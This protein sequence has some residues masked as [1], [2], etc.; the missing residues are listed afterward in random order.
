MH[1]SIA[2]RLLLI[3]GLVV[4][5]TALITAAPASAA[6]MTCNLSHVTK[7]TPGLEQN[8]PPDAPDA[9]QTFAFHGTLTGCTGG[10]AGVTSG[11]ATGTLKSL[12][13]AKPQ[14]S[15][16]A[17]VGAKAGTP[18]GKVGVIKWNNGKIT[19]TSLLVTVDAPSHG[20]LSGGP[21]SG[22]LAGKQVGGATT[23]N[24]SQG[25]CSDATPVI[26]LTGTGTVTLT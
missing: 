8:T 22:Y 4:P 10:P 3:A 6:T 23:F 21:T 1:R 16:L 25:N 9:V 15:D 20:T 18:S 19:K 24:I 17:Q 2:V 26:Q 7:V 14:C 11:N 13:P 12:S 5:T